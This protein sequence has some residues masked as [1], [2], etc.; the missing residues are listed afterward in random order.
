MLTAANNDNLCASLAEAI[1]AS[2]AA[3]LA[4][5]SVSESPA[6]S[7]CTGF[8]VGA[9]RRRAAGAGRDV[10]VLD[11]EVVGGVDVDR[12]HAV[13]ASDTWTWLVVAVRTSPSTY[14]CS[15]GVEHLDPLGGAGSGSCGRAPFAWAGLVAAEL[16]LVSRL[17]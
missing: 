14:R 7:V 11:A 1:E 15:W 6:A 10:E 5:I 2:P 16:A 9:Q 13:V 8:A 12:H 4:S 3:R 17:P